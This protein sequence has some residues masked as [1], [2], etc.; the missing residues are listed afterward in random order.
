MVLFFSRG[1]NKMTKQ[2]KPVMLNI[3]NS[4]I[5][6]SSITEIYSRLIQILFC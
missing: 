5:I 3:F 4:L 6:I 2:V 1:F